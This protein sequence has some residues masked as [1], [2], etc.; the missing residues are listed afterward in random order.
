MW[1]TLY[2]PSKLF[3]AGL[4]RIRNRQFPSQILVAFRSADTLERY[5]ASIAPIRQRRQILPN[6]LPIGSR[7]WC[8]SDMDCVLA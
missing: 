6:E 8:R 7:R 2:E 4:D 3:I 1:P 5:L